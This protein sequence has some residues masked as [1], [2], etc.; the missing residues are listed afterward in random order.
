MD[1]LGILQ[2]WGAAPVAKVSPR[3]TRRGLALLYIEKM[4]LIGGASD[5]G[6]KQK[7]ISLEP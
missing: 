3:C 1:T 7:Y 6:S 4:Q 2:S 5:A